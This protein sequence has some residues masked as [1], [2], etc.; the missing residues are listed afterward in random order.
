[1]SANRDQPNTPIRYFDADAPRPESVTARGGRY[2]NVITL[3]DDEQAPIDEFKARRA[4]LMCK[5]DITVYDGRDENGKLGSW[6]LEEHGFEFVAAPEPIEDFNDRICIHENYAPHLAGLLKELTGARHAFLIGQ[7][8]RSEET[9]RGTTSASYARFAHSDYGPEFE[10]MF[11]ELL[12]ARYGISSEYANRCGLSTV[13]F[14][15]PID[16]PAFKDPLCLLDFRSVNIVEHMQRYLYLGN[17]N[18]ISDRPESE[19]IPAASQDAPAQAPVYDPAHRW[20]YA[21]DMDPTEA[22][23]FKH[24]DWRDDGGARA[25]FHTSFRDKFHDNWPQCPARRSIE[26]RFLLAFD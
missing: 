6:N 9:G 22:I 18:Y 4:E 12:H 14:W 24:Y 19:R 25:C 2:D 16:R 3:G 26:V 11:R 17:L 15:A 7:Q 1:V 5:Q 21:P 10:S 13:G 8:V 23:V 20:V